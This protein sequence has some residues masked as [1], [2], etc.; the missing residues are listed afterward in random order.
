MGLKA[1]ATFFIPGLDFGEDILKGIG[2][3]FEGRN[4]QTEDEI[5]D[6]VH[7]ADAVISPTSIQPYT[8][9]VIES[10]ARCR[11]IA[12]VGVGYE[13]IDLDAATERGICVTNVPD[14]CLDE[15]SDHAMALL[16]SCARKLSI[17]NR[18]IR[19][20]GWTGSAEMRK[21]ILP[22]MFRLRG[23][24]LG[25]VGL[26]HIAR[27]LLPKARGFGLRLIAYKVISHV[28]YEQC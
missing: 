10:L 27:S 25:I 13:S 24:T 20:G 2:A 17:L 3:E 9:R 12:S 4:C 26:G 23:Q 22:P 14:Y 28:D 18:A 6:F 16:L 1:K 8:R 11:I 21:H 15:V 7:D 5:I 19:R